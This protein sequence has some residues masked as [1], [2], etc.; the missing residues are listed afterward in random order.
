[1]DGRPE[2]VTVATADRHELAMQELAMVATTE[3]AD[4]RHALGRLR[5]RGIAGGALVLVTGSP[6][7]SHLALYRTLGSDYTRTL[8][9]AVTDGTNEALGS[10]PSRWGADGGDRSERALVGRVA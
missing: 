3:G 8:V 10:L 5:Q 6:S 2:A 4:L 1:M 7:D 9:M